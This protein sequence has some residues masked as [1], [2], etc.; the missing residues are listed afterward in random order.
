MDKMKEGSKEVK[1]NN[2]NKIHK[3][4]FTK[5]CK[6]VETEVEKETKG[7]DTDESLNDF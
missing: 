3:A 7:K 4:P 5:V 1:D 2:N 6:A